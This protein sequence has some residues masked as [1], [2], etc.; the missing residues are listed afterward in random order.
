MGERTFGKASVQ[1]IIPLGDGSAVKLTIALYYTPSGRSIQAE[2]IVPDIEIPFEMP[3]E[4]DP[5]RPKFKDT[6]EKDLSGHIEVGGS[7][8]EQDTE[9][10]ALVEDDTKTILEKDN[11]LRMGLQLV[12][13][14]PKIV[15]VHTK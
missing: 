10:R 1:E 13:G 11:Q 4:S 15:E 14:L 6:S 8:K 9:K 3:R 7:K 5:K 12:R 2:G